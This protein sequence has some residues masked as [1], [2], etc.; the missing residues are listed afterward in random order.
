VV[1]RGAQQLPLYNEI[2]AGFLLGGF[3][4]VLGDDVVN[5]GARARVG[6]WTVR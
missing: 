2:T 6:A 1:G 4:A 5:L 3:I